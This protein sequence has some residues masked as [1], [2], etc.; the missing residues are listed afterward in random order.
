MVDELSDGID[1][2]LFSL[3][4]L[5]SDLSFAF[6]FSFG[7]SDLGIGRSPRVGQVRMAMTM[8]DP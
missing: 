7:P 6:F 3:L 8:H 4:G 5:K 2:L 1:L